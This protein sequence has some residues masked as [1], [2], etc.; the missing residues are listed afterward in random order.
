MDVTL[1]LNF[2][3]GEGM[4]ARTN[5]FSDLASAVHSDGNE[6]ASSSSNPTPPSDQSTVVPWRERN[7]VGRNSRSAW[8]A[9]GFVLPLQ[10][11]AVKQA[12]TEIRQLTPSTALF[13]PGPSL[14]PRS[15]RHMSVDSRSS[16]ASSTSSFTTHTHS[17]LASTS[18]TWDG[19]TTGAVSDAPRPEFRLSDPISITPGWQQHASL[20]PVHQDGITSNESKADDFS[21]VMSATS[22]RFS[23]HK[24]TSS[25]PD[26]L[27][28]EQQ[29]RQFSPFGDRKSTLPNQH[30]SHQDPVHNAPHLE[31]TNYINTSASS[32]N[33]GQLRCMHDANCE[34]GS[35][36]RKAISHIFGRNKLCT[37]LIPDHVW[38]HFCRKHYQRSRYRDTREY[39]R[40]QCS[41]IS[42]QIRK[43]HDWSEENKKKGPDMVVKN[44]T[45]TL[46]KREKSRL[47]E[48]PRKRPHSAMENDQGDDNV[49]NKKIFVPESPLDGPEKSGSAVPDWLRSKCREGYST[50]EIEGIVHRLTQEIENE[51]KSKIPDIEILPN[52]E[53]ADA[54]SRTLNK[55]PSSSGMTHKRSRSH[56]ISLRTAPHSYGNPMPQTIPTQYPGFG[57]QRKEPY[58]FGGHSMNQHL[59]PLY[60]PPS[61]AHTPNPYYT[62][63]SPYL[64]PL[65]PQFSPVTQAPVMQGAPQRDLTGPFSTPAYTFNNDWSS[66]NDWGNCNGNYTGYSTHEH[67]TSHN[68]SQNTSPNNSF[69]NSD[70]NNN[71]SGSLMG[72]G[73]FQSL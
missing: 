12:S 60:L 46:R 64:P 28:V 50:E 22:V 1:L 73:S 39:A 72:N 52:I 48:M 18:T 17:R 35:V 15:P 6:E 59:P 8:D 10:N 45:L 20:E 19:Y 30:S 40:R 32:L 56:S 44:W 31:S 53:I 58:F 51:G 55:R 66:N 65:V 67:S 3:N 33:Y 42:Q 61:I 14:S 4:A 7:R 29:D 25:A 57:D 47:D 43:I 5:D 54:N 38:V 16:L 21:F 26:K 23:P 62:Q 13:S 2:A 63:P 11:S 34:T 70:G 37:R 49:N 41:L 27:S 36:L 68:G 71:N 9:S 24:R 69:Y